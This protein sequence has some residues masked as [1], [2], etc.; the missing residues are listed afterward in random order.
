MYEQNKLNLMAEIE[1]EKGGGGE[2]SQKVKWV[3]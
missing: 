3:V 1:N 2:G